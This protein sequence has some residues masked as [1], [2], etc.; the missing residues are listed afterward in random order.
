MA[1]RADILVAR[2]RLGFGAEGR[3]E[4]FLV[5]QSDLLAGI[6]T[7]VV[8][9]LDD[10]QPMYDGDP[11]AVHV[12]SKEAGTKGGQVVLVHLLVA[13][14]LSKFE[15]ASAGRLLPKSMAQVDD[16]MRTVLHL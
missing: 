2:R 6:E 4:H 1:K 14:P 9:P 10:D 7:V 13:A 12:S 15:L 16:A 5:V 8:A 3:R 11:L